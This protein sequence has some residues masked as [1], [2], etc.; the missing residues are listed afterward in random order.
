MAA[1]RG[2]G[3][4][5]GLSTSRFVLKSCLALLRVPEV[6]PDGQELPPCWAAFY[7]RTRTEGS[8]R[9]R[10]FVC[11]KPRRTPAWTLRRHRRLWSSAR[12]SKRTCFLDPEQEGPADL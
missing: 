8:N 5:T 12:L 10:S 2:P 11:T 7:R 1:G 9:E 6:V 4:E 3:H